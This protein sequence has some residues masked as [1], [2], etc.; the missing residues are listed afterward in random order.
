MLIVR[1]ISHTFFSDPNDMLLMEIT[2]NC[3]GCFKLLFR[4]E[5]P[6]LVLCLLTSRRADNRGPLSV[7]GQQQHGRAICL[8]NATLAF[9]FPPLTQRESYSV[10]IDI[11]FPVLVV[12]YYIKTRTSTYY[13]AAVILIFLQH[14]KVVLWPT[15]LRGSVLKLQQNSAWRFTFSIK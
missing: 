8:I 15:S 12:C 10:M 14:G 4:S 9:L 6:P 13:A 3:C 11:I 1:K 2:A 7:A 5:F